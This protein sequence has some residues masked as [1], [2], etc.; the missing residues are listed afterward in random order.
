MI[1][2]H[3]VARI[4]GHAVDSHGDII[5]KN[6]RERE[7]QQD[8]I[9]INHYAVRS[10]EEFVEKQSRGRAAGRTR[11]LKLDYFYRFDLND[12]KEE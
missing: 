7:P 1:G 12:I 10:F 2:C 3:E 6:F 8:V 4:S 9:R 11:V 5:K